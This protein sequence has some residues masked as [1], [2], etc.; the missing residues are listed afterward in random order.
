[1]DQKLL[2]CARD[3]DP[4]AFFCGSALDERACVGS[5]SCEAGDLLG[6]VPLSTGSLLEPRWRTLVPRPKVGNDVMY[7]PACRTSSLML[8]S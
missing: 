4:Q 8:V 2:S 6:D 3:L 1:V 5:V 7:P